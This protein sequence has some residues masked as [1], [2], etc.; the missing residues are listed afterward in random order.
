MTFHNDTLKE[1]EEKF[2]KIGMYGV[3]PIP[4]EI[5]KSFLTSRHNAYTK[6]LIEKIGERSIPLE[7]SETSF[8]AGYKVG[9]SHALS[10]IINLIKEV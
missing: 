9:Y 7:F 3:K 8:G 10:D 2:V 4:P 6:L 1:L 5:V